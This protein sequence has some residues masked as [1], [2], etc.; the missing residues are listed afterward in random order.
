MGAPG[1]EVAGGRDP[2][3]PISA[4]TEQLLDSAPDGVIIVDAN[5]LIRLVN[6]Q[7]ELLFG[8]E[9]EELLGQLLEILVPDRLRSI[10]PQHRAAYFAHPIARPMGA[11]LTLA[12]RRKDGS[13]FPVDISLSSVETEDGVLVSAAVRDVTDRKR[14]EDERAQLEARLADAERDEERAVLAAQLQQSQRLE[15]IGQLAGGVAHDFNNLLAGIMNYAALVSTGLKDVSALHGLSDD[16][17]FATLAQ[18]VQAITDVAK[19]AATLTRQLLIFSR[20]EVVQPEVLDLRS[21]VRDMENLLRTTIGENVDLRTNFPADVTRINADRGQIEQVLMNLA[22]NA[23]DAMPTGGTLD[24]ATTTFEVDAEYARVHPIAPGTYVRLTVSD[25]GTG[26]ASDVRA[27]AFEPFF[28]TKPKGEGSGLGLP[29]VYG[30]V[31]QAG[32]DVVIYS[33]PGLGTTMSVILPAAADDARGRLEHGSQTTPTT[34][35][36]E[37]ILLVED[38]QIV[39]EPTRRLLASHG[40]TVMA[41]ANADDALALVADHPGEIHLL[42]TD[43]VMPGRSGKE[44]AIA[45]NEIRPGTKTLFMSGYSHDLILHQGVLEEGVHLIEKPF[46]AETLL[47]SVRAVLDGNH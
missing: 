3:T 47:S 21:I 37:T 40:Y 39:R 30:I 16:E 43:V 15:S 22:V 1:H 34:A 8:Y 24:I 32:G 33:E 19:R 41:A 28:T 20:R 10:H 6:R 29:T 13:E 38:E 31:T 45:V 36:D 26:M 27:R 9:R 4:S 46:A 2:P 42:L 7:A 23:R 11:L 18:D 25:T 44:L 5:G 14:I 17:A 35:N 12:A